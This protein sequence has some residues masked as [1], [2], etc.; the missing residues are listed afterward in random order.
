MLK[1]G[2][3]VLVGVSGGPDSTALLYV[4]NALKKEYGL[5]LFVAHLNHMIR[6][7]S[8][9]KDALFVKRTAEKLNLPVVIESK[10]VP[11]AAK[12]RRRS[13]EEAAR[14]LRYE[15]FKEVLGKYQAQ[16]VATAHTLNDQ[17]ET[18]L[19]R[20]LRGSG[21][22]GL[23]GIPPV[24]EGYIIR[25]LIETPRS[26]IEEFLRMKGVDWVEDSSNW[27]R[28]FLRNRIR[29]ELIPELEKYNPRIK[30]T[31]ARTAKL[32]RTEEDFIKKEAVKKLGSVFTISE[33]DELI[34]TTTR[35]KT[36][37]EAIRLVVLRLA[38]EKLKG[39]LRKITS[40]HIFSVDELLHS[41]TP[42]GEISLPDGI[43]V[44]K[45]YDLFLV[46]RKSELMRE[47]S[48][49]IHSTGKWSFPEVE[50]EVEITK[51]KRP[52]KDKSIG[53]FDADTVE[54]PIEVRNFRPGDRFIPL[55]MKT[56]RSGVSPIEPG[57]KRDFVVSAQSNEGS[58]R[59]TK[60]VKRFFIDEKVPRFLRNRIPIFLSKGKIMLVETFVRN[61]VLSLF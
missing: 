38:V 8:A 26:E 19:M 11:K 15:F 50:F 39:S 52:S 23:S 43:V 31:L 42:S 12:E 14:V 16:K 34:G 5:E 54:F 59:T 7:T 1:K 53:F 55:G 27:A 33:Q 35:Y 30:K 3:R 28:D 25:P 48:Y 58:Q 40:D 47:F 45:G 49:R 46:T 6:K 9:P 2:D 61:S 44:I 57:I 51:V 36:I 13:L 22:V 18:V 4:L 37:P 24:S 10:D 60:K 20:I 32:L 29:L 56:S 17:A 21:G 41:Q